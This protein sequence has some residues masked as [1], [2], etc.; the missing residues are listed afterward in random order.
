LVVLYLLW[1]QFDPEEFRK[2]SWT[3]HTLVWIGLAILLLIGRHLAYSYRLRVLSDKKFSWKK[4]I[5]L[6]FIWDFSSAVS[7][8]SLGGSAVALFVLSQ[9]KL[10]TAKTSTIVIYTVV[11]DTIF[12]IL[13]LPVLLVLLGPEIIRP[14]LTEFHGLD[15]WGF[16]FLTAYVFMAVYGALFFYGLWVNPRQIKRLM[17]GFTMLSF[18]KKYRAKAIQLG[19]DIIIT[20]KELRFKPVWYHLSAFLA[21]AVAWSFRFLLLSAIIIAIVDGISLDFLTQSRLYARLQS[22]FV[23]MAFSPT[24]GGSGFAEYVFGGFLSDFVPKGIALVVALIWRMLAYYTYLIAGIII[25]PNWLNGI[26]RERKKR[27]QIQS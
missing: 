10:P 9:E 1:R 17:V 3:A 15:G 26:L 27:R 25:I 23:I 5:E 18:L 24:P 12:F 8:T 11:L 7:P 6:I 21:T 20:S 22:M 14:G 16:T 4:C 13:T 19:D 2:I